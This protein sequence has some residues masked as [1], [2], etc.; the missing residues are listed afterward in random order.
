M[1]IVLRLPDEILLAILETLHSIS[2]D[3]KLYGVKNDLLSVRLVCQRLA[4]IGEPL[5]FKYIVLV[6]DKE[7]IE[8]LFK[9][10]RSLL[11][12]HVQ[13]LIC[14]FEDYMAELALDIGTFIDSF[15]LGEMSFKIQEKFFDEYCRGCKY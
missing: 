10:S 9:L 2:N 14:C 5:A 11:C 1:A 8:R 7:G 12:Q 15:K 4:R 6:Q 3:L 13:H